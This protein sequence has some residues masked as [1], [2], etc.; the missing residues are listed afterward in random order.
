M[1]PFGASPEP[2]ISMGISAALSQHLKSISGSPFRASQEQIMRPPESFSRYSDE[3]TQRMPR[4]SQEPIRTPLGASQEPLWKNP[5]ACSDVTQGILDAF[6]RPCRTSQDPLRRH[7]RASQEP[8]K[9]F[10]RAS[11]EAL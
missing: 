9:S 2:L 5:R 3:V 4:A 11:H 8:L 1:K 10:L 7:A 6:Q